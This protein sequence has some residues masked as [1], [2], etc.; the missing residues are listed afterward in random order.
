MTELKY[1]EF[2]DVKVT[3]VCEGCCPGCYQDSIPNE[4][5]YP[6]IID[7]INSFFK[8]M[9]ENQRP[10]Q[11]ALGGGEPTSHP[12]FHEVL[13]TFT[14]LGIVPNY[15][16]NGMI[17]IDQKKTDDLITVTKQY[18]GGVAVSTHPHLEKYWRPMTD[19]LVNAGISTNLHVIIS[20]KETVDRFI[21]LYNEYKDKIKYFVLLPFERM[22][23]G[24]NINETVDY[25][26]LFDMLKTLPDISNISYGANFY[27]ELKK[28][29]YLDVNLYEPEMFSK[30][31][32]LKDMTVHKSSFQLDYTKKMYII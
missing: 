2:Y 5:H 1:P 29:P 12:D 13:K 28:R 26:Y 22:G 16:T 30:Y 24:V 25:E 9:D 20:G 10:F 18:C 8:P 6:N 27:E 19:I 31:V 3:N 11:V 15:T 21:E 23:R 4:D 32:D 14:D 7:S 17:C